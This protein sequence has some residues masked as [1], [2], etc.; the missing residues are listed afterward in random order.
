MSGAENKQLTTIRSD[1]RVFIN[2]RLVRS[3]A[4]DP[5]KILK[6]VKENSRDPFIHVLADLLECQPTLDAIQAFANRYPDRWAQ[7]VTMMARLAGYNETLEVKNDL[8]INVRDKSDSEL[9]RELG[10]MVDLKEIKP[11]LFAVDKV[12]SQVETAPDGV[13]EQLEMFD[14][15][16]GE[17]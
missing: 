2:Q 3:S 9:L 15:A 14:K 7:A 13:G 5:R 8:T 1:G 12:V 10:K 4:L 11:G 17:G 16:D 6:L